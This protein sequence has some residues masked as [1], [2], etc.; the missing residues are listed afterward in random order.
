MT[1]IRP[2]PYAPTLQPQSTA[3]DAAKMAAVRAMFASAMGQAS[4]AEPS[5]TAAQA[6]ASRAPSSTELSDPPQ[7]ILRP[8][9]LLDIRV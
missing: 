4:P 1:P 2:Q 9:S 3:A 5:P 8:G 6:P 7:K